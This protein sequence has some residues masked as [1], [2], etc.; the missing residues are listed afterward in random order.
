MKNS[1]EI[2]VI[3]IGGSYAGLSAAMS[4]GRA[5]RQVLIIDSG[6]PC[7]KQTPH[8]HNFITHD[9]ETPGEIA[10]KAREQVSLYDTVRFSSDLAISGKKTET[11][12]EITTQSG[13]VS[14]GKK[15][16]FATGLKDIM[17]AVKGFSECWGISVLHC[18]YCHGY[19]V[20][21][22]KTGIIA[23]GE[24]AIHYAQL[25]LNWT[26]DLWLFTD[27]KSTLS[28]EQTG[29]IAR[30]NIQLIE[31]EI[32]YLEHENGKVR[33]VVLKTGLKIPLNAVYSR[34]HFVQHCKIPEELGC[35]LTEQG[36]IKVD[37][38]Q[39]TSVEGVYACGDNSGMR[40]VSVAVATGTVAGA[41]LNNELTA[42]EFNL[43][44]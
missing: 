9:G 1:K 8:S 23:S 5:L 18:P 21:N 15:L 36:L 40:A 14:V 3:V 11:G 20:K 27:G 35:E 10:K 31:D 2:E 6:L 17:P 41:S 38:F 13:N 42:E 24:V 32:D 30:N 44:E 25:I 7:N 16:I 37:H 33:H 28:A 43:M 19:E 22:E 4:L 12:F 34:P 29:K 39:K 26:R